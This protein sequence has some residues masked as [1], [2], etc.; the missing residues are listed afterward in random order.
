MKS[1][2]DIQQQLQAGKF[3]FT[4]HAFKRA[5]ERNIS[6]QEIRE[7]GE[8]AEIIEDYPEDKYSPSSL[9]SGFTRKERTL[10][11]QVSR[12]ESEITRIITLYEPNANEWI[13]YRTRRK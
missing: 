5:I 13:D 7:I 8:N 2:F 12:M 3:E 4:Q 10:H 11:I 6:E 1:I 9:L